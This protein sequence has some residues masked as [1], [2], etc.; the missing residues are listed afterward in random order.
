LSEAVGDAGIDD[1]AEGAQM[2][3]A[4]EDLAVIGAMVAAMSE[5]DLD[6]SMEIAGISGQMNAV[7]DLVASMDMLVLASFLW[8]RSDRLRELAVETMIRFSAG[9]AL[10]EAIE[11][12]EEEIEELGANEIA[13]GLVRLEMADE[14]AAEASMMAT[15]GIIS[16]EASMIEAA[17]AEE[18]RM[19]ALE[20]VGDAVSEIAEGAAEVGAGE[21][22]AMDSDEDSA[23]NA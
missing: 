6:H 8:D 17:V 2:L 15:A 3:A 13:E 18:L 5:D 11:E 19:A 1:I 4:S 20:E 21:V 16:A 23:E 10:A 12:A 14:F 9:Q 22:L 7:G